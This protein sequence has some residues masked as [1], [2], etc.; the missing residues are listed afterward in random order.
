MFQMSEK[1]QEIREYIKPNGKSPFREWLHDLKDT[2]ARVKI[3]AR[4]NRIRLGN[5][6]D[7][8]SVGGGVNEL[9]INFGPGIE[10]IS[11]VLNKR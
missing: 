7:S 2:Q 4:L 5:F 3:R 10:F 9:R 1:A 11:V 6:G 8:K